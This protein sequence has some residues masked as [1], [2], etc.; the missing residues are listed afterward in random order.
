MLED[1]DV[2]IPD[3]PKISSA[4][5]QLI[6]KILV[7]DF[8][9]RIEWKDIFEYTITEGGEIFLPG[10]TPPSSTQFGLRASIRNS[11]NFGSGGLKFNANSSYGQFGT[12]SIKGGTLTKPEDAR[13][14]LMKK[15]SPLKVE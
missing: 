8:T 9:N 4:L 13:N 5:H 3:S 6:K 10:V 11:T 1:E 12:E 15:K 14:F 7:K 2:M